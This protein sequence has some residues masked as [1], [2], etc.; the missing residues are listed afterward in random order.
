MGDRQRH[1]APERVQHPVGLIGCVQVVVKEPA[2]GLPL[3]RP[4]VLMGGTRGRVS[5]DE[6]VETELASCGPGQQVIPE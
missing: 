1:P 6:V 4:G 3:L 2:D 5:A